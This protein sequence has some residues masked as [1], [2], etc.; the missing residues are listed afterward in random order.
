ML[1]TGAV[2]DVDRQCDRSEVRPRARPERGD[3]EAP[4]VGRAS[5][6]VEAED[7]RKLTAGLGRLRAWRPP[8]GPR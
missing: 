7:G 8:G 1:P 6:E 5:E 3:E 2:E 4:E